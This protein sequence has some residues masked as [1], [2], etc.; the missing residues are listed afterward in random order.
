MVILIRED[1]T[2]HELLC[3]RR[4]IYT[5]CVQQNQLKLITIQIML[6]QF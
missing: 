4:A 2:P 5:I 1:F 3:Y 6:L